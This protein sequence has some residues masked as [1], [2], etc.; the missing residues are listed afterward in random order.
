MPRFKVWGKV[1]SFITYE[2]EAPTLSEAAQRADTA[3]DAACAEGLV[4]ELHREV[5][6][7][8]IEKDQ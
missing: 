2:L 8:S 5:E 1:T 3:Y 6:F 4:Q 7:T